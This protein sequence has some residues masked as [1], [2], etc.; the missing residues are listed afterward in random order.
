MEISLIS[1]N[2]EVKEEKDKV[3]LMTVHAVKD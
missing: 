2:E 1:S 3:S